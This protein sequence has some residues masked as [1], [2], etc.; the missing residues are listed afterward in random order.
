[1]LPAAAYVDAEVL[2]W[3]REHPLATG[4]IAVAHLSSLGAAGAQRAACAGTGSV[5]VVRDGVELRAFANVCRHRG[6]E[7]LGAGEAACRSSIRCPYHGWTYALDGRLRRATGGY[8]DLET[9]GLALVGVRVAE[10]LGW[11]FVNP[12]GDAPPPHELF[13]GLDDVLGP[14]DV[15]DLV[16]AERHVYDVGANWKVIHENYQECL[17]C[18]L[19]HPELCR[20]TPPDSGE[21]LAPGPSWV[22][23]WMDLAAGAA[24]MSMTGAAVSTP[25]PRLDERTRRRVA[26]LALLP[27][28]LVS[29]HPDYVLTHLLEPLAPDRTRVT[30]EW[31]VSPGTS[32][33]AI[34]GAVELWDRT[35]RQDWAACESVQRGLA[36]G[37][38]VP[39]PMAPREDAVHDVVRWFAAH[40]LAAAPG[41]ER[42]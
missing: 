35:N 14:Y 26:Y 28:L 6:H 2:R 25:R 18:G 11:V 5:L 16:A 22:G 36:S 27:T 10:H 3:E 8:A 34:A 39:G 31:L 37:A 40:Y 38:Y 13:A 42:E 17:H 19:I 24:T 23:G 32:R 4:W 12:S 41:P 21:N 7:L 33:D 29:A 15:A 30:C 9:D 20:V 1:M